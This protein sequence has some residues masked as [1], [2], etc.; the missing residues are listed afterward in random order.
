MNRLKFYNTT[1]VDG[2]TELDFLDHSLSSFE[3][4]YDPSYYM[5]EDV[6]SIRPDLISYK[7]Y[8]SVEYW[9]IILLINNIEDPMTELTTGTVIKIPNILD[10][11]EFNKRYRVR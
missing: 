7:M 10:I 11:Y 9:W 6:D 2:T 3:L 4:K 8:G 1:V 5:M